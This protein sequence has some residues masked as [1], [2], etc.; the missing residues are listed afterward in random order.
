L[1]R[2]CIACG[3]GRM[4]GWYCNCVLLQWNRSGQVFHRS[5]SGCT[6][7]PPTHENLNRKENTNC[8]LFISLRHTIVNPL[9]VTVSLRVHVHPHCR[10][11]KLSFQLFFIL[12]SEASVNSIKNTFDFLKMFM[13]LAFFGNYV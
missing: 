5:R 8:L 7:K 12:Q 3:A 6:H 4:L 2:T 1:Y 10:K 13:K 9:L 11:C